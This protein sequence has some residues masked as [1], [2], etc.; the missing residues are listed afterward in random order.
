[1]SVIETSPANDGQPVLAGSAVSVARVVGA[2]YELGLDAASALGDSAIGEERALAA[3]SYCAQ[4]RCDDEGGRCIGCRLRIEDAG[5]AT[6]DALLAQYAEVSFA[7]SPLRVTGAGSGRL[8]H[9]DTLDSLAR[10]W[11][12]EEYWFLARRVLRRLK[13]KQE[14]GGKLGAIDGDAAPAFILVEP[15]MADNIGMVA[16]AMANFDIGDLRLVRARD[17][18]PN[19][20]ARFA[21]SGAHPIIDDATAHESVAAA[22]ADLHWVCATTARSRPLAK[23][24]LTPEAAV[25]EMHRRHAQGQRCGVL[26][27][28]ERAGLTT[29]DVALADAVVMAPVS[30]AFPSLNLAQ[31]ALLVGYE[32]M[33]QR[34]RGGDRAIGEQR[35]FGSP[36][37]TKEAVISF[38]DDLEERLAAAGHFN[39]PDKRRTMSRNLRTLFER[40]EPTEQDIRTLRGILVTLTRARNRAGDD[41]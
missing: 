5:W 21:A 24:V 2:A 16:R 22:M 11:N 33:R 31:A 25:A 28:P 18:W 41:G 39:P 6:L 23:P 35:N 12:G 1:L 27:G 40:M 4:R 19:D 20:K 10:C 3:L 26:F 7:C 30:A 32:W 14:R 8:H 13:H 38:L 17:G 15:Q 37:A 34:D 36:P 29:D 9:S